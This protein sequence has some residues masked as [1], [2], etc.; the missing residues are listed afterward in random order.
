MDCSAKNAETMACE[1]LTF[2]NCLAAYLGARA[3]QRKII[4]VENE[5]RFNPQGVR[6]RLMA[7]HA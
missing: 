1:Y 4:R 6:A 7:R 3:A 2:K 5:G